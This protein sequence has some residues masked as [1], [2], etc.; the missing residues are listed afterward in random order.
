[1][2]ALYFAQPGWTSSE[3]NGGSILTQTVAVPEE[4]TIIL[5]IVG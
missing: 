4:K 1:M 3:N 5:T 2:L